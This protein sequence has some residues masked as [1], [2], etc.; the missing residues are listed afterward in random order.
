M[1]RAADEAGR[2]RAVIDVM[3]KRSILDPQGRAV[4]ATLH[5]LGH[6]NVSN[7]RIGKRIELELHGAR[8]DVE[9]QLAKLAETVLSNPV[10][11]AVEV[12]LEPIE[13]GSEAGSGAGSGS[14]SAEGPEAGSGAGSQAG[15]ASPSDAP[16]GSGA[17]S[18]REAPPG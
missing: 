1:S 6:A 11:E 18:A 14:G 9:D 13:R 7:L 5:R 15:A 8:S 4:E 2:F 17:T 10:M 16:A 3:L 12:K